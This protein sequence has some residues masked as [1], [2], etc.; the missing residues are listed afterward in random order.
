MDIVKIIGENIKS[1]MKERSISYRELGREI[2]VSHPTMKRYVNGEQPMDSE[3]LMRVAKYFNKP[4]ESFFRE[5]SNDEA[6][7]TFMFRADKAS[8]HV[9][10]IDLDRMRLSIQ[11]YLDVMD[12]DD[13]HSIPGKY[14]L[15]SEGK[16]V[17][18]AKL[19]MK[20][21]KIANAHRRILDIENVIPEN[22]YDVFA[23]AGINVIVR[24]FNNPDFFGM[25][26]YAENNGCFII[27]NDDE[28]IPEERKLF[29]LVHEYAHL[30]FDRE[31]Y[32]KDNKDVFYTSGRADMSEK[33]ANKFAGY[34]LMPRHKVEA[35]AK[36]KDNLD[37]V[38][39]KKHFK[40]SLQGLFVMLREY[41]I[42]SKASSDRFW[43][44]TMANGALKEE[45][46]PM[47]S[48][49]LEK[50]NVRLIEKLKDDYLNGTISANKISEVLG[51]SIVDVRKLLRRWSELDERY[52]H[53]R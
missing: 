45:P 21:E 16:K 23:S 38:M 10:E 29:T 13:V 37:L 17:L 43:K 35:Y 1:L 48:L 50:K 36:D 39:M 15:P 7:F 3:K 30:L 28:N 40:V 53:H 24:K 42:I 52:I 26:S 9:A 44:R 32:S 8:E 11:G 14:S 25:S 12:H 46:Y 20:L 19:K 6:V 33:I 47:E 34:F 2:G 18:S 31:Q 51:L 27:V 41:K 4:F 49:S 5:C 22:Y